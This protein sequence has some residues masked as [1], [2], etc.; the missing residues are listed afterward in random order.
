MVRTQKNTLHV[1]FATKM[2]SDRA[3]PELA[4]MVQL[5]LQVSLVP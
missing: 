3:R 4:Y 1:R 2:T 5:A